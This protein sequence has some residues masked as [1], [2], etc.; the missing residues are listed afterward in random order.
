MRSCGMSMRLYSAIIVGLML[1]LIAYSTT[2]RS[3]SGQRIIPIDGFSLERFTSR[4]SAPD[5]TP[6]VRGREDETLSF[7]ILQRPMP[8]SRDERTVNQ[9]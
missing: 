2:T 5:K 9:P 6:T 4:S 7:L 1:R 3:A 8:V